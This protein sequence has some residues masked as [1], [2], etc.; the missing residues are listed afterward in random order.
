M[1]KPIY[2]MLWIFFVYKQ[3][4]V[5]LQRLNLHTG[6]AAQ[7]PAQGQLLREERISGCSHLWL[8]L[9][10]TDCIL[11]QNSIYCMDI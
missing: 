9:D 7:S 4:S 1:N 2:N 11:P 5:N 10:R 8:S 3:S 6:G